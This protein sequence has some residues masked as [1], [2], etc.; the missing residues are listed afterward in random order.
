MRLRRSNTRPVKYCKECGNEIPFYH[1]KSKKFCTPKCKRNFSG[2][3]HTSSL[4][5]LSLSKGTLGSLN[6]LRVSV[7]LVLK[8]YDVFR[9]LSPNG[10][11]DLVAIK[12]HKPFRVEVTTGFMYQKSLRHAKNLKSKSV[13]DRFDVLAVVAPN[14][15]ITYIPASF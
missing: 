1:N 12:N 4:L 11:C 7:D 15:T 5:A 13:T 14:S 8:G 10:S 6:E 2:H 9:A 3:I